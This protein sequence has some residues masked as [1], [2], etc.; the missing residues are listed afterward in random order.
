MVT[1]FFIRSSASRREEDILALRQVPWGIL[2]ARATFSEDGQRRDRAL[3]T[4]YAIGKRDYGRAR[5]SA[6]N[7]HTATELINSTEQQS[8]RPDANDLSDSNRLRD[9]FEL[10]NAA[11]AITRNS[12]MSFHRARRGK[13]KNR[14]KMFPEIY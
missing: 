8:Q 13:Q 5:A 6:S 12:A 1:V 10:I 11:N 3:N 4:K 7:E 14:K 9:G 2:A